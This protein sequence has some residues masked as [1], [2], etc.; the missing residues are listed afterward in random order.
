MRSSFIRY[1]AAAGLL[2]A[3]CVS[4]AAAQ[5]SA[6]ILMYHRFG[7][8]AL[9]STSIRLDQLDNHIAAL[10][11]GGHTVVPL[12]D[13]VAAL[14]GDMDLPD[15]AVA[16]TVDD[17]YRSFLTDGWPRFK[18]AGFPVTVFVS[19]AGVDAA[20][21]DL[22]TWQDI[23]ALRQAGVAIGAHSHGHGHYPGMS[24]A[25]VDQDLALMR[26]SFVRA[27]G[28]VPRVFAYPYGEAG[29]ADMAA[30]KAAEYE[31]ALG[32]H[33]GAAGPMADRFYLPRFALNQ[34]FGTLERFRLVI[35]T[36]PL[37][38]SGVDPAEPV[39]KNNPPALTFTMSHP[40]ANIAALTCFGPG[41]TPLETAVDNAQVWITLV[42]P[43]PAGR[44]RVNC[45][46]PARGPGLNGRWHWFGW[47]MI[48][49]FESEGVAVDPRYR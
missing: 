36:L 17:A 35:D 41:G 25:G 45:T 37:P 22:L 49:G 5:S 28:D 26:A 39:L 7:E 23:R 40:P 13:V 18:A 21:S 8:A 16:I 34:T 47:Q 38:V 19:T 32:Q 46:L 2:T 4:A 10:K 44:S 12:T 43:F 14:R 27:L 33:S 6:V 9:P 48:A 3:W 1:C 42:Q 20:F 31:A 29:L 30:V 15:R 11:A 24:A